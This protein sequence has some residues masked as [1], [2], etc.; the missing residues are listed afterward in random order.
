MP[1]C[2]RASIGG[3]TMRACIGYSGRSGR[4]ACRPTSAAM[5]TRPMAATRPVASA[6]LSTAA[7]VQVARARRHDAFAR[8]PST[9]SY[10]PGFGVPRYGRSAAAASR[11]AP[12]GKARCGQRV[13]DAVSQSGPRPDRLPVGPQLVSARPGLR[14]RLRRATPAARDC[15]AR[16]SL[17]T[18]ALGCGSSL[19]A[20]ARLPRCQ[21]CRHRRSP[22]A[23]R[24]APGQPRRRL[25][26][27]PVA[28]RRLGV[29]GSAHAPTAASSSAPTASS[30]CARHGGCGRLASRGQAAQRARPSRSS[31]CATTAASAARP[32]SAFA[33]K[34]VV[35]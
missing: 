32:G 2:S 12:A 30:T 18:R 5:T 13:G 33:T 11:S 15:K 20:N 4:T 7:G 25:Q 23:P 16:P 29:G 8:R 3:A 24:R 6:T 9:T 27:R 19:R 17:R 34:A 31:R 26:R 14:F 35:V 28:A 21:R 10:F 22:A 1:T